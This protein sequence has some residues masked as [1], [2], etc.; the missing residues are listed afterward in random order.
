MSSEVLQ[1]LL[2]KNTIFAG[3]KHLLVVILVM[4]VLGAVVPSCSDAP[5]YDRRL[6]TADSLMHD[7]PDSALAI[8]EAVNRDS[9]TT[10]HDIAYRDLLLT[11]ARYKVYIPA[12]SDSDINRALDYYTTHPKEQEKLTRAY[13]YKGAVMD[14]LGYPDSAMFYYRHA[15]ASAAPDDYFN[16]GYINMRIASLYQVQYSQD[17]SAIICKKKAIRYFK[18]TNDTNYLITC[19]GDLGGLCGIKYPDSSEYYLKRAIE[20]ARLSNS[21]KQYTYKS[22]LAGFY[23]YNF[24]D[25]QRAKDLAMDV[26]RNGKDISEENQFYSYAT[27]SY[28]KL[29]LLDSAKIVFEATPAPVDAVDSM[30]WHKTAAEIAEFEKNMAAYG[31]NMTQSKDKQI[32]I[33]ANKKGD[34]L[35]TTESEYDKM[36]AVNHDKKTK[37]I[38]SFLS[39]AMSFAIVFS[40]LLLCWGYHLW[41]VIKRNRKERKEIVQTL[42]VTIKDLEEKQSDLQGRHCELQEKRRELQERHRDLQERHRG[43]EEKQRDLQEMQDSVTKL[44]AYRIEALNELFDS[45]KFKTKKNSKKNS[46]SHIRSIVPLSSVISGLSEDYHP[47]N[48]E[49]SDSFWE[50][51]KRSV[52]GEYKGIASYFEKNNRLFCLLCAKIS[53]QIIKLCMNYT[54]SK[55]ATN[56]R[57]IL[58]KKKMRLDMTFDEFIE[59]YMKNQL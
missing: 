3:V 35:K 56:N 22:R 11:Q 34:R 6:T 24:N 15:E 39:I 1:H 10:E 23:F 16:L 43:L 36:Q 4:L 8:I 41:Q 52:D 47:L 33:M 46:D 13:L 17:T 2:Q 7:Y 5:R 55:S 57:N 20:L 45:I 32:Q 27:R 54:N 28:L 50:K 49:L 31:I 40:I 12:T 51:I 58:I 37:Q 9:L 29:G 30:N 42:T 14:E 19:Y 38:N 53:P 18:M 26:F 59:Q 21:P 25:Y 44:V 48:V